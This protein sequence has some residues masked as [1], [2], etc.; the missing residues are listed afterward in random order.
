VIVAG[1]FAKAC[2]PWTQEEGC[3]L[4]PS[5][6]QQCIDPTLGKINV[7]EHR[8]KIAQMYLSFEVPSDILTQ[9]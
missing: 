2:P 4:F 6:S 3:V 9:Q 7:G 5:S 8:R 1:S